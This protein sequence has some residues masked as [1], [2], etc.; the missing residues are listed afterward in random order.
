MWHHVGFLFQHV[1]AIWHI[2]SMMA[3]HQVLWITSSR[4]CIPNIGIFQGVSMEGKFPR[5]HP[6]MDLSMPFA[7]IYFRDD[8]SLNYL[9]YSASKI[10]NCLLFFNLFSPTCSFPWYVFSFHILFTDGKKR[11]VQKTFLEDLYIFPTIVFRKFF[12]DLANFL[13]FC[14]TMKDSGLTEKEKRQIYSITE[15][16]SEKLGLWNNLT[17]ALIV[18][19]F[20]ITS[21]CK[22]F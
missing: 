18:S 19:N 16:L 2:P 7:P 10:E 5:E 1:C 14:Q 12:C 3:H 9:I 17:K 22:T 11:E 4:I 15:T 21:W 20:R 13:W 6:K 8:L